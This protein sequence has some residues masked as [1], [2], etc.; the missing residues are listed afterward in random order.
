MIM[1]TNNIIIYS[2]ITENHKVHD[3]VQWLVQPKPSGVIY[4]PVAIDGICVYPVGN[5]EL[6]NS[7]NRGHHLKVIYLELFHYKLVIVNRIFVIR[8]QQYIP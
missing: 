4:L 3:H 6:E 7:A 2:M 5:Y 1:Y 8:T